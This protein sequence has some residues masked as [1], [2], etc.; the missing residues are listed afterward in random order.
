[1]KTYTPHF[2]YIEHPEDT[3]TGATET[4]LNML[5]A[6]ILGALDGGRVVCTRITEHEA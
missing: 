2:Q 1:M 6:Q 3:Y 4:D 5:A